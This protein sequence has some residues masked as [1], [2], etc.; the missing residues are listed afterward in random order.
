MKNSLT[1]TLL[2]LILL[3]CGSSFAEPV[4]GTAWKEA[5][6]G[7]EFV[8]VPSGCFQMGSASGEKDEQ[9]I[10]KVCVKGFWMGKY[11]VTQAQYQ[12]V[13]G[14][15]PSGFENDNNPVE[16]VNWHEAKSFAVKM[17][18]STGEII[19]LPSEAEW[20]YACRA[21][22]VH[23]TFCGGGDKPDGLLWHRFNSKKTTHEAG[24]LAA[25]NWGLHDMSGNVWEWVADCWNENYA[26]APTDGS[27][28]ES[29]DCGKRVLRGGAWNFA[30]TFSRAS[31][32]YYDRSSERDKDSGFRVVRTHK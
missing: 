4:A 14:N 8:W 21:G 5:K 24:Q 10:H 17:S 15:D 12:Q 27:A 25:N 19:R 9:P 20:E 31:I 1:A 18:S 7:M 3:P 2:A 32:R 28:R 6:T 29:G 16:E 30:P 22:G 11:E 26:G 23:E 13:T